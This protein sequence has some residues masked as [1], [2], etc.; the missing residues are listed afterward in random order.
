[1]DLNETSSWMVA[2]VGE[3][4]HVERYRQAREKH[5][6]LAPYPTVHALRVRLDDFSEDVYAES[7]ALTRAL[8]TEAQESRHPFWTMVLQ[9]AYHPM[10]CR[11]RSRIYGNAVPPDELDHMVSV[12]FLDAI[13]EVP[14]DPKY[15][16]LPL[17]LRQATQRKLFRYL[18]DEQRLKT[19]V[20]LADHDD[21]RWMAEEY[22]VPEGDDPS[23]HKWE[24]LWPATTP[25]EHTELDLEDQQRQ[26]A[27]LVEYAGDSLTLEQL[28]ALVATHVC[29]QRLVDHA[30][31]VTRGQPP[32]TRRRSYQRIRRSH[33][34]AK[35][36]L[37]AELGHL[38]KG[39]T[40][41][42]SGSTPRERL[43]ARS[44][45]AVSRLAHCPGCRRH[46]PGGAAPAASADHSRTS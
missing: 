30:M 35:E 14:I 40:P 2:A 46:R 38:R 29:G 8:L 20:Q 37:R 33:S 32:A 19:N 12:S 7:E 42:G 27:L 17:R 6:A 1:M 24:C 22:Y 41:A 36:K 43:R 45:D 10:L 28:D 44:H 31:R 26:V 15:D 39:R 11:L 13:L 18:R 23:S 5:P 21:I 3:L 25:P 16:H 4:E 34:R 9:I